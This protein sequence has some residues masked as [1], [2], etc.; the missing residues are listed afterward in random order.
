VSF[1][2]YEARLRH[3][4]A[5]PPCCSV[6]SVRDAEGTARV[7]G[8]RHT[9]LDLREAFMELVIEPFMESY[10]KGQTP[11]PCI[12]CNRHIK[13]PF[14]LRL[15]RDTGAD[16]IATGHYA[17]IHDGRLLKGIDPAKDQSYVL[18][19]LSR[20]IL[21]SLLL[22]L[23]DRNKEEVR[24][25]AADLGLPAAKRPESQEICFIEERSYV[26][27]LDAVTP[28]AE[29]PIIDIGTGPEIGQHR[30]I[31]RYTLGQRKRL[32]ATGKPLYVV[33]MDPLTN[34][35]YVGPR[36]SAMM[37]DFTVTDLNW[38]GTPSDSGP[39]R[40]FRAT[41]K[42]RSTMRDEPAT[43]S[44][45][46]ERCIRVSYDLPQWAPAPGQSAVLY[47]GD[48]VIGGGVITAESMFCPK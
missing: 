47:D 20:D 10:K 29:G 8:I 17:R 35:V 31:H 4:F 45:V 18:Y 37:R 36:E 1:I 43:I 33:R 2:L 40:P 22:P 19:V 9:A 7:L 13:F 44:P 46:D 42:V 41:V 38:I 48:A 28:H 21:E 14:L 25:I 12:L 16:A 3:A 30:G 27:L 5:H 26:G 39:D 15:A 6:S 23:G 32:V 34:T 24:R 11:N